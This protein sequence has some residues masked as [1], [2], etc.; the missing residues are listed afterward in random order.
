MPLIYT[1]EPLP[2]VTLAIWHLTE[3]I[4]ELSDRVFLHPEEKLTLRSY[5][6]E[7]RKK[8][9]LAARALVQLIT[10]SSPM[11]C[12]DEHGKPFFSNGVAHLSI[13]H[14]GQ[15]VAIILSRTI[16]AGIDIEVPRDKIL[17]VANRFLSPVEALNLHEPGY[18]NKLM[19]HWC[20]KEA[21]FKMTGIPGLDL[22]NEIVISGFDYLCGTWGKCLGT[23]LHRDRSTT[24]P[25]YFLV[26]AGFI[27]AYTLTREY[28]ENEKEPAD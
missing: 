21:L 7:L 20:A 27:L 13:S 15:F 14:S 28:T 24:F 6:N 23:I 26:E 12:Y 17:R 3:D 18:M 1:Y 22:Q 16:L 19:I 5:K 9:W 25:V 4:P 2:A 11:I 10:Q 8:Q